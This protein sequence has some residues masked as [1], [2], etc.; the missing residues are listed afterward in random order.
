[1]AQR[2]SAVLKKVPDLNKPQI[3]KAKNFE[4]D[5]AIW[6]QADGTENSAIIWLPIF[7]REKLTLGLWLEI[8]KPE[9]KPLPSPENLQLL[10]TFLT[11][12]YGSS[13]EKFMP[14]YWFRKFKLDRRKITYATLA[15]LLLLFFI[16]VPLRV[17][18]PCE[19][20]PNDPYLIT[21]PLDG[22]VKQID[23]KAGQNVKKGEV[24]FEYEKNV[25]LEELKAA[26]KEV[27]IAQAELNR[28]SALRS[29]RSK[30][31]GRS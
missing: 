8:W 9:E 13:W 26:E 20:V 25:P 31:E 22:I 30:I 28:A 7:V 15:L 23:V 10:A 29:C 3:L 16:R 18:A 17:V 12:V 2:W 19:V 11:P 6:K 1:M 4:E 5:Q 24:L 14:K 21:A 27:Q